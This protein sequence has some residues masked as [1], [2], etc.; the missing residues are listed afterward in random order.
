VI[1][2]RQPRRRLGRV[3]AELL[4]DKATNPD[5]QHQQVQFITELV[6]RASTRGPERASGAVAEDT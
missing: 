3:A 6:V 2:V 1:S 4:L 5:H